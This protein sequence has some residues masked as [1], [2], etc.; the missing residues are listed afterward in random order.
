MEVALKIWISVVLAVYFVRFLV[1]ISDPFIAL[2]VSEAELI[3][4][5]CNH[6]RQTLRKRRQALASSP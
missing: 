3:S 1:S 6:W 5:A 2:A 4:W